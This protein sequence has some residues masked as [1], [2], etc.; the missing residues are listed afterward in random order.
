[1]SAALVSKALILNGLGFGN[2]VRRVVAQQF[3]CQ[4]SALATRNNKLALKR[5]CQSYTAAGCGSAASAKPTCDQSS[6]PAESQRNG[7][8]GSSH[9]RTAKA[10]EDSHHQ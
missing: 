3:I 10:A 4:F 6:R 8:K 2:V 1:M 5:Q 7:S 9:P